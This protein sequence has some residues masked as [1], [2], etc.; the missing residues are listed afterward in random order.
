MDN[1]NYKYKV[2]ESRL[3]Y[4]SFLFFVFLD[5]IFISHITTNSIS[6]FYSLLFVLLVIGFTYF[7]INLKD[8][9]IYLI[10]N[11]PIPRPKFTTI[12]RNITPIEILLMISMIAEIMMTGFYYF[13]GETLFYILLLFTD[14]LKDISLSETKN[15]NWRLISG[16][17]WAITR[18]VIIFIIIIFNGMYLW[19]YI[20]LS[21]YVIIFIFTCFDLDYLNTR[22]FIPD[23]FYIVIAFDELVYIRFIVI[24]IPILI[25]LYYY[26][27]R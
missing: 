21:L 24:T 17:Q 5:A 8:K 6:L 14:F 26:I 25:H 4:K 27:Y 10:R 2:Y 7:I 1:I 18:S 22:M 20:I 16:A 9:K 11:D 19:M 13:L 12:T 15:S 3:N 23:A